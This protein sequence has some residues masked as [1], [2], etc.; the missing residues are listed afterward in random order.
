MAKSCIK[1]IAYPLTKEQQDVMKS[2][3]KNLMDAIRILEGAECI[4]EKSPCFSDACELYK[5]VESA[6]NL[7]G[8]IASAEKNYMYIKA[9]MSSLYGS[10]SGSTQGSI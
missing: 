2:V 1:I 3:A 5:R 9:D 4:N 6:L 10:S 7:S 8:K